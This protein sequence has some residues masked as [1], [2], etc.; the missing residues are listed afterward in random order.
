VIH[1]RTDNDLISGLVGNAVRVC[2]LRPEQ[3]D[4]SEN[5][6]LIHLQLHDMYSAALVSL[7]H[8][9]DGTA[10]THPTPMKPPASP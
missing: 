2:P 8:R 4:V 5:V 1:V 3:V 6:L 9:P 7:L 10:T